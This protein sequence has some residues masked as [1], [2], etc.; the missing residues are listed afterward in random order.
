VVGSGD[1]GDICAAAG[2]G[3]V[4]RAGLLATARAAAMAALQS[5]RGKSNI[6]QADVRAL[7][8]AICQLLGLAN[9]EGKIK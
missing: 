8:I 6:T 7:L 1:C 4:A 9:E 5:V 2:D 3:L